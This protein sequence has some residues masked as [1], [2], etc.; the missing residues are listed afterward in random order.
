M[1]AIGA[2]VFNPADVAVDRLLLHR[3]GEDV[4]AL[5]VPFLDEA[6]RVEDEADAVALD[7]RRASVAGQSQAAVGCCRFDG[8][9]GS[10][11]FLQGELCIGHFVARFAPSR[12][13]LMAQAHVEHIFAVRGGRCAEGHDE[14]TRCAGGDAA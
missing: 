9:Q 7:G 12:S 4:D 10:R 2:F 13:L 5:D 1:V 11:A 8:G 6:L 3:C 14:S